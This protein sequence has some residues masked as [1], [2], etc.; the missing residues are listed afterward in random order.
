MIY[1]IIAAFRFVADVID[2]ARALRV[3]MHRRYAVIGE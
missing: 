1:R 3:A 2:D